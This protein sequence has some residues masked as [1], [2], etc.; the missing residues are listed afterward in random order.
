L[1]WECALEMDLLQRCDQK[2]KLQHFHFLEDWILEHSRG[3][4]FP[5]E[6]GGC[7]VLDDE[8]ISSKAGNIEV[9]ML[10]TRKSGKEGSTVDVF[11]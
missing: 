7:Y 5:K 2:D 4:F 6:V 10:S 9:K 11:V 1:K 3:L 8:L